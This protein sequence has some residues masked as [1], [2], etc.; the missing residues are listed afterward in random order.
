MLAILEEL[1]HLSDVVLVS[2]DGVEYSGHKVFLSRYSKV[3]QDM[4][5][6][7]PHQAPKTENTFLKFEDMDS[8][9]LEQFLKCVYSEITVFPEINLK[10]VKVLTEAARKYEMTKLLKACDNFSSSF[11][12]LDST[13]VLDWMV[14]AHE[15]GLPKLSSKCEAFI[16]SGDISEIFGSL[17]QR[18]FEDSIQSTVAVSIL[19]T[20][21]KE[22]K[23]ASESRK[24]LRYAKENTFGTNYSS[25]G[26]FGESADAC[27]IN[28]A[29]CRALNDSQ[30]RKV[31]AWIS[32]DAGYSQRY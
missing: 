27:T 12:K 13:S 31:M 17:I 21:H 9:Q 7:T 23:E 18:P 19:K 25:S 26:W 5:L 28:K 24:L 8:G 10:N 29:L 22:L 1:E 6:T 15:Y 3:F 32:S 11:V 2:S 4:F 14:F 16:K 30:V 20:A